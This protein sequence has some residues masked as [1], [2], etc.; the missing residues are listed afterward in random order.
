MST[1]VKCDK[2]GAKYYVGSA[3]AIAVMLFSGLVIPTWGAVTEIG[4]CCLGVFVGVIIA[5]I[6]TGETLWPTMVAI[7][8]LTLGGYF[9]SISVAI[10]S[11]FGHQ[12]VYGFFLI[13]AI[14]TAMNDAGTGVSIASILLTRKF[15]QRKPMLLSYCFLIVFSIA[16]NFMNTVG[17]MLLAFPILDAILDFAGISRKDKY[18]KFMNLGL[19][20]AICLGFTYRSAVMP[21]FAFRFDFFDNALADYGMSVNAGVY[22]IFEIVTGFVFFAFYVLAMKYVF[23]CDFGRLAS[24]DFREIESLRR[25]AHMD[26]YQMTFIL[27]FLV[28][29]L[30]GLVPSSFTTLSKIGQYGVLGLVCLVLSFMKRKDKEGNTVKLFDFEK[31]L[32]TV[33]WN[34][35]MAFGI[36]SVL[37]T[38]IGSDVC[39]IKQWLLDSVGPVL[40]D[41]GSIAMGIVCVVGV[42]LITN[43][44]NNNAVAT[45]FA[46]LAAPLSTTFIVNGQ[47]NPAVLLAAISLGSQS[48]F[49]TMAASGT[50]PLLHTREGIDNKFIWT[51]GL[52]MEL[53]FIVVL[54]AMYLI[55]H[56][57]F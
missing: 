43:V 41:S 23:K 27:G 54:F 13:T 11:T 4:V 48:G 10:S 25:N 15:F 42:S 20:L 31:Y 46:S 3:I 33:N 38:A 19:F 21:D 34:V 32:K 14:I 53:L 39:G 35:A 45:I 24:T 8:A 22:T 30:F 44:F 12:L 56:L 2:R 37:G 55:F 57:I 51:G 16:V 47:L 1:Q 52:F 40:A 26:K 6:F 7:V 17:T 49:L 29:A 9:D 18:A 28:F 50:A 5:V 36:F